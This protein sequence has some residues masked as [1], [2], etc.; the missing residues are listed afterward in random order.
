LPL[1]EVSAFAGMSKEN[2]MKVVEGLTKVL[3]DLGI[4]K[5]A[6]SVIIHEIPKTNW[7][8]GGILASELKFG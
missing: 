7:G 5:Q 3:E 2:K 4:P 6:I 8:L 1:V